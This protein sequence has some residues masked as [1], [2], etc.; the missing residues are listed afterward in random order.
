MKR[1]AA[2]LS[3][4]LLLLG[5]T[6]GLALAK[7]TLDQSNTACHTGWG[8]D[9]PLAQTF[10]PSRTG[11]LTQVDVFITMPAETAIDLKIDST[12][13]IDMGA[14]PTDTELGHGSNPK[15]HFEAWYSFGLSGPLTVTSGHTYAI[16]LAA[17]QGSW[18]AS[19]SDSYWKRGQAWFE[20]PTWTAMTTSSGTDDFDFRTYVD[21]PAPTPTPSPS[22]SPTPAAT[23]VPTPAPTLAPGATD[24][25]SSAASGSSTISSAPGA[26]DTLIAVA[27]STAGEPAG[28]A[29]PGATAASSGQ[30]DSQSSGSTG[31]SGPPMPLVLGGIAVLAVVLGSLGFL[32]MRRRRHATG[33]PSGDA[34][35]SGPTGGPSGDA[36][37]GDAPSGDPS[38]DA[39]TGP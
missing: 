27:S 30:P 17:G 26:T 8:D 10:T 24:T 1:Y 23:P 25:P 36:P 21:S 18:C 2:A 34:P 29:E 19:G 5:L 39:P 6:P 35:T 33:G 20:N 16:V 15:V 38:G 37:W 31:S 14:H 13:G 7:S 9:H 28:S 11:I 32:L 3:A 12:F 22:P 4:G